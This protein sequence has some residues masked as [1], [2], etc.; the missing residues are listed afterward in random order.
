MESNILITPMYL[1]NRNHM[2]PSLFYLRR[3][4]ISIILV[5]YF[6][7]I[8]GCSS[9]RGIINFNSLR[10]PASMSAFL[11]DQN[12]KVV[13][14]GRELESLYSFKYKKTF[15]SLAYGLI[16]L[17]NG[18]SISKYLNE[19]VDQYKGDG[20]INLTI[21][22]EQGGINKFYS[23]LMYLPSYIPIFP[24]SALITVSGEVVKLKQSGYSYIFENNLKDNFISKDN[25]ELKI[26]ETLFKNAK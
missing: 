20:I 18:E 15:W 14:K 22:I 21:T 8:N 1:K 17:S 5:L 16:P 9:T 3:I 4:S 19:I 13:M 11:S 10:Y 2:K 6:I 26:D 25:I 24:G 12:Q 7:L 23:F